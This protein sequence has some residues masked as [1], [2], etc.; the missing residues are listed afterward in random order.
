M[1]IRLAARATALKPSATIAAAQKARELRA[2][3]IH[4]Y[5]FSLGEPDFPTPQHICEAAAEAMR[6]GKTHY[7]PSS[8][9]PE[10]RAAVAERYRSRGVRYEPNEIVISNGAKHALHNVLTVLC[11]SGDQVLIPAPYW[12]SYR[13][14]VELTGAEA[15]IIATDEATGFKLTPVQ[16]RSALNDRVKVLM[17][18]SPCNPTGAVYTPEELLSLAE[19]LRDTD[20]VILSDEIYEDLVYGAEYA[21]PLASLSSALRERTV[22][23]SGVSKSFAMTGWRIGWSAAPRP[24]AAAIEKLQSQQTSN[25]CSISQYAALAAL[26]GDPA[27]VHQMKNQFARRRELVAA[28]LAEIPGLRA[29]EPAGAFYYFINIH[30]VLGRSLDGAEVRDSVSF[31][32]VC[33]ETAHVA[34][35]PGAAF[36]A[37]GY[38]RMSFAAS[39]ENLTAG[40]DALRRLLA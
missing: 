11:E 21:P 28:R 18:N 25:P 14:L 27:C 35:V 22:T 30:D 15:V 13:A 34:L 4:V 10:L 23:V 20:V 33:L 6:G 1:Q 38:V 36:G 29:L 37:E 3:G 32:T 26:Q 19:V 40:L 12:V 24:I 2:R 8:G 31:C 5:D 7:T 17:L 39:E 16:L 9:I